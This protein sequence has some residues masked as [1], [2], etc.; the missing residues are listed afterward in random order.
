[1]VRGV[2]RFVVG[3]SG[4][5]DS[6]A[7]A[8][9]SKWASRRC[10]SGVRVVIVDHQLQQGSDEVAERTRDLLAR[11]GMDACVRRVDVDADDP[12]GPEAAARTARRAALL[13]VAGDEPVL[14]G[15]TRDDQPS[16]C[17]FLWPGAPGRRRWQVFGRVPVSFGIRC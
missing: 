12:D 10:E 6:L 4:G 9:A 17:C 2:D 15:H 5:P 7:L 14:L 16:R 11:R 13:D 3:C 1:M 8:L